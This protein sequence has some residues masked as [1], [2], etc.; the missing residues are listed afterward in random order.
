M[1]TA[2]HKMAMAG[3]EPRQGAMDAMQMLHDMWLDMQQLKL[4]TAQPQQPGGQ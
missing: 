2:R 4:Q 1:A 3:E